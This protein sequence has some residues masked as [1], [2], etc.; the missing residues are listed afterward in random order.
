[1]PAGLKRRPLNLFMTADAVGGVW[2]YATDLAAELAA[3]HGVRVMLA[4]LGPPPSLAQLAEA[5]AAG[6]G[7][8]ETGL[9]LDW[10]AACPGE[11]L[12]AG[13]RLA[14]AAADLGADLV[15]LNSPALLA[16]A[17]FAVPVV[18]VQHSCLATWWQAVRGGQMPADF[19]W[20]SALVARG[21]RR[22]D[23]LVAPTSAFAAATAA[24]Y[25]LPI[26][27]I[28]VP[29]GR[30]QPPARPPAIAAPPARPFAFTAGRLWDDGKN[31]RTLDRA[32]ARLPFHV[33]AAGPLHGPNGTTVEL[34]HIEPLGSLP[35]T[36]IAAWLALRP[37]FVSPA[38][39][40]PFGLAALEAAQAGCP[41][42]L[43]DIPTFRELWRGAALLVPP[44]DDRALAEALI[45]VARDEVLH[46]RLARA[47]RERAARF[48]PA[49]TAARMIGVYRTLLPEFDDREASATA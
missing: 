28:V 35:G 17:R 39:Y 31:L 19:L 30:R 26:P 49:A 47:A 16:E 37:I 24:A 4:L 46:A 23:A 21:L 22:A 3:G 41:L 34:R 7:V 27:P 40:E 5:A 8:V 15:Q 9:P 10:L 11:V 14:E 32:A 25:D 6:V 48:T 38:L 1:M 20:R 33:H 42:V 29:N 18:A 43:S 44:A 36:E 2:Q 13:T 45:R 12:A